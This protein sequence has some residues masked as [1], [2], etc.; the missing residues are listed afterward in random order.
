LSHQCLMQRS[1]SQYLHKSCSVSPVGLYHHTKINNALFLVDWP[2][3]LE[4]AASLSSGRRS[5][6][7]RE[8][9]SPVYKSQ[10]KF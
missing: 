10:F 1:G 8:N 4:H 2:F 6:A 5:A 9:L 3:K 7:F